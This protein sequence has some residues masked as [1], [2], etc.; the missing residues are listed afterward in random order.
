MNTTN[1]PRHRILVVD[2]DLRLRDLLKRYLTEQG[3]AAD[4][5]PDGAGLDRAAI[6]ALRGAAQ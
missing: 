3:F 2:D 4:T 5:V 1:P 6:E